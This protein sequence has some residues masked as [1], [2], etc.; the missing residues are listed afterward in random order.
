[1]KLKKTLALTLAAVTV[2]VCICI[3]P[4]SAATVDNAQVQSINQQIAANKDKQDQLNAELNALQGKLDA[5]WEQKLVIDKM[6]DATMQQQETLTTLIAQL[7]AEINDL[8]ER[9]IEATK[10][11]EEQRRAF[12]DRMVA[13]HEDGTISYLELIFGAED[14]NTF[15]TKYDYVTSMLDYDKKVIAELKATK[16]ELAKT[17][18]QKE[19]ALETQKKSK[20]YYD[21]ES[22]RLESL[23]ASQDAVVNSIQN[24]VSQKEALKSQA[25][26][27]ENELDAK[28][29]ETLLEIQRQ[30][31][32][33]KQ[34][35]AEQ[36]QQQQQ[37]EQ[38]KQPPTNYAPAPN[39]S[40][41][42][43]FMWPLTTG[44]ISSPFGGRNLNGV[45][46]FHR[47]TD[48]ACPTG[49]PIYAANSGTVVTSQWH[50]SYGNYVLINHGNGIATLYAHMSARLCS[51]GQ[52]VE[53][54]SVIG[55]VGN[56][57][58]SFGSHLHFEYR[59][60]GE[61]VDA[62]QQIPH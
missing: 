30:E 57:G 55:L 22:A 48:I 24:N 62:E 1:M 18:E 58:Y 2:G 52:Y 8:S 60:N 46:E 28:L 41:D 25:E 37:Q 38:Q 27:V 15:L 40:A 47:A 59:I 9:D 5:E 12:L 4:S 6:V 21:S 7:E 13:L 31:E 39:V 56:T 51:A 61:C 33:A 43:S 50:D 11:M 36:Q 45:Y 23:K 10:K 19:A 32:L 20:E 26:A 29:K 49:T 35:A 53:K 17:R 34:Q 16:E 14:L 42:G 44:Y 54:G 3:A